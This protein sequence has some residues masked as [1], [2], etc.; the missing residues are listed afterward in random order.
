[1][2]ELPK[3]FLL[4]IVFAVAWYF[5]RWLNRPPQPSAGV[6]RRAA[7][8][9]PASQPAIDAEDLVACGV[10]GTYVALN[11]RGCGKAGCPRPA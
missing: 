1:M 3:L 8:A 7:T 6:R 11:A 4:V 5:M 10:C 2:I 9:R